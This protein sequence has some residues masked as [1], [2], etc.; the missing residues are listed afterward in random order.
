[1]SLPTYLSAL[2]LSALPVDYP[3]D[4]T[5]SNRFW[6]AN[7]EDNPRLANA[8][9]LI[10]VRAAW[11]LG[12]ACSEWV[13][14]RVD[15]HVDTAD[16]LLRIEAA[17]AAASDR[18]HA[19]LPRPAPNPPSAPAEFAGPLRLAMRLLTNGLDLYQGAGTGVRSGT[20]ALAMLVEH[21][22]GRHPAFSPWLSESLRRAHQYF[23]RIDVPVEQEPAVSKELYEPDFVWRDGMAQQSLDRFVSTLDPSRNPYLRLP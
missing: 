18:R 16:A 9:G 3:W 13:V 7:D 1:M 6:A 12:V 2:N 19:S 14:A 4:N 8:L 17:W 22:C 23:P 5:V 10:S 21:I 11:A 20:Q 15:G